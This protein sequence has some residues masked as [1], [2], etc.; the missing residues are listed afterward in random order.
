MRLVLN[1]KIAFDVVPI[2]FL[3][4]LFSVDLLLLVHRSMSVNSPFR[5]LFRI[6]G[7]RE[8]FPRIVYTDIIHTKTIQNLPGL[9]ITVDTEF[10]PREVA[11]IDSEG[12]I[13]GR[14]VNI[15]PGR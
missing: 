1:R 14:I 5:E 8:A 13:S 6:F 15:G 2:V 10:N 9:N 3:G 11:V 4:R 12:R 7:L